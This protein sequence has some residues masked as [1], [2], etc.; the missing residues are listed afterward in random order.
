MFKL[1]FFNLLLLFLMRA[2]PWIVLP[3]TR[4]SRAR[5]YHKGVVQKSNIDL[6]C[7]CVDDTVKE[8]VLL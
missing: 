7:L 5:Q 2:L 6:L 3:L 4:S 8:I 1:I